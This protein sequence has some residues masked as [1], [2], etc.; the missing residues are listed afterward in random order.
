LFIEINIRYNF[1]KN[2]SFANNTFVLG[3]GIFMNYFSSNKSIILG[4]V[5][6]YKRI[7]DFTQ[8]FMAL[9]FVGKHQLSEALS[10]EIWCFKFVRGSDTNLGQSL[11]LGLRAL[12]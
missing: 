8:D 3:S 6:Y 9:N 12:F 11:N 5:E 7:D 2:A 10:L 1:G 4:F